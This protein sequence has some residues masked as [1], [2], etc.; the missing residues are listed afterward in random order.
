MKLEE[1]GENQIVFNYGEIGT[2]FFLII[3][4]S[5]RVLIPSTQVYEFTFVEYVKFLRDHN[6]LILSINGN[7]IFQIPYPINRIFSNPIFQEAETF[8]R[9]FIDQLMATTKKRDLQ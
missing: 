7:K 3:K 9:N 5:V 8:D 1:F 4:G 2:K 6:K